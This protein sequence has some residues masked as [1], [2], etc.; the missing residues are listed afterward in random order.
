MSYRRS[1]ASILAAISAMAIWMLFPTSVAAQNGAS[2]KS[3]TPSRTPDGQPDLQGIWTNSTLTQ[4]ERPAD[5]ASKPVVTEA[6]AMAYERSTLTQRSRDRR[7]GGPEVDVGRAYNELFFEQGDKLERIDGKI[8]TSMIVDPPDG[9][10]PALTP[11]AQAKQEALRAHAQLH[12]ADSPRDRS[13]PER[14]LFWPTSGPPM[15]PGPYNN[16]YQIVQTPGYVLIFS[17]MIHEPRIIPLDGRPHL[18]PGTRLW[19]GDSRGHW[20]GNTLVVETTNFNGKARFRGSDEN[21]RVTERFTRVAG[22]AIVYKFTIDDPTV[23]TKPWTGEL[24]F[25]AT[26]GPIYEY[27]CHEGNYAL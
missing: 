17:E 5:F 8:R 26:S 6:E 3:W 19:L 23:F 11:E 10:I 13:L 21:L 27:A 20:E 7:D 2:A 25:L 18:P 22:D 16:N 15:L 14:C 1:Q 9:R 24:P 4:L 12:P